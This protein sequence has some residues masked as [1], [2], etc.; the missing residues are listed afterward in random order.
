MANTSTKKNVGRTTKARRQGNA[1]SEVASGTR[2]VNGRAVAKQGRGQSTARTAGTDD[3]PATPR[4]T[5]G[6]VRKP[7]KSTVTGPAREGRRSSSAAGGGAARRNTGKV[8]Q[9]TRQR[10]ETATRRR[11][12]SSAG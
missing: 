8:A 5:S 4:K 7:R 9:Q 3:K 10:G 11:K 12:R 6:G 2:R 1:A